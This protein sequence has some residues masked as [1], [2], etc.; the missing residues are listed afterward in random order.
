MNLLGHVRALYPGCRHALQSHDCLAGGTSV[1]VV[2]VVEVAVV[3]RSG[4]GG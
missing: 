4:R 1:A 3:V 2:V